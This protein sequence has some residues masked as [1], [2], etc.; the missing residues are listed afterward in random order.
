MERMLAK[1]SVIAD[2]TWLKRSHILKD[3]TII[4]M[5]TRI[6][7]AAITGA[8]L[9]LLLM[10]ICSTGARASSAAYTWKSVTIDGGGFVD[11]IVCHP[12]AQ[13]VIY[14]RTDVGGAYR[15]N[16]GTNS[17]EQMFAWIPSSNGNAA[18]IESL[19]VDPTHSNIVYA[20]GGFSGDG[21]FFASQNQGHTWTT[22]PLPFVCGAN[23]NGRQMGERLAVDPND[24]SVLLYGSIQNGLFESANHG[25][26]WS[27]VTSFPVTT[28]SDGAGIPF[29]QFV[30]S[31][32][33]KGKP[34]PEIFAGVSQTGSNVYESTNGGSNWTPVY[35]SSTLM[36]A[37]ASQDGVGNMYMTLN[38]ATGPNG[39][40][41][42]AVIKLNLSTLSASTV[43]STPSGW[44]YGYGS[45]SVSKQNSNEVVASTIDRW[46]PND[47]LYLST[48]GGATWKDTSANAT[49][50]ISL[51]PWIGSYD[52]L[53]S[54]DGSAQIDPFD[55]NRVFFGTGGGTTIVTNLTDSSANYTFN[56]VGI[57]EMVPLGLCCPSTG[58]LLYMVFGDIGGFADTD[59]TAS[60]SLSE[61]F[62]VGGTIRGLDFAALAPS[63]LAILADTTPHEG[64]FSASGGSSWTNFASAPSTLQGYW[65]GDIAVSSHGTSL[66]W[67]PGDSTQFYSNNGGTT[68]TQS[69][70]GA[71]YA[72][73]YECP[74]FSD[75]V[76]EG[77]FYAY[78]L[79]AGN[80]LRSTN[81]GELF[82][83]VSSGVLPYWNSAALY[84]VP[85]IAGD[86]WLP[87][88]VGLYHSTSGG[89]IW[90]E[91]NTGHI[92]CMGFGKAA[93]GSSYPAIF[94]YGTLTSGAAVNGIFMST[95]EGASWTEI[96]DPLD[97]W[98]GPGII[99]GDPTNF[100]RVY[101]GCG[102]MGAV[103]GDLAPNMPVNGSYSIANY[104][105]QL[106]L[107]NRASMESGTKIHQESPT[108]SA[109]Q[110]WLVINLGNSQVKIIND[111][112]GMALSVHGDSDLEGA[113]IV[114]EPWVNSQYQVWTLSL[115]SNGYYVLTNAGSGMVLNDPGKSKVLGTAQNQW[116]N[117]SGAG[118]EW[119]F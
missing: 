32:G 16:E 25:Q 33:K 11:G 51:S 62:S 69:S 56:S 80:F 105:S 22:Y 3:G 38:D 68:W 57:E 41:A 70:G 73:Y 77:V 55:S 72:S 89:S 18:G 64:A 96:D 28:T 85:G 106:V 43:L 48:D 93:P 13:N 21:T 6:A 116:P 7:S 49:V 52:P 53:G 95:D 24:P 119:R 71:S 86:I 40:S 81:G 39:I 34:T 42:G 109:G 20:V 19:A 107:D 92:Q 75:R 12:S 113:A 115:Q 15:W 36:P 63:D 102:G 58:S 46:W 99:E 114:Q 65:A 31:T 66:V 10:G 5:I 61:H 100:G 112:S 4:S 118:Q 30:K 103:Y 101:L 117:K 94:A 17:W 97:Q 83:V 50:D 29:V 2:L 47:G 60:P 1:R 79:A 9:T 87:T 82:S 91:I 8:L 23:N 98:G 104:Y 76:T 26:T 59:L 88:S 45:V 78:D 111:G 84:C 90:T 74:A 108:S 14:A 44:E 67:T 27:Q 35:S 37:R 110:Q 54:W